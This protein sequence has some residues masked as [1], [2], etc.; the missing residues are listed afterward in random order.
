[1]ARAV[2]AAGTRMAEVLVLG[3]R[4]PA[5]LELVRRFAAQ[6]WR[7]H[8]ADSGP[9]QLGGWSRHVAS[10]TRLASPRQAPAD[11]LQGLQALLQR[12]SI[13]VVLPTCEEIFHL[14]RAR[15][16]LPATLRVLAM[17]LPTLRRLHSKWQVLAL[18]RDRG[19]PAPDTA[20]VD[21]LAQ[22]R[23][24]AAG[25]GVVLKP[26]YSRFGTQLRCHPGGIPD[27]AAE[28]PAGAGPWLAQQWCSGREV[29]SYA[30]ADAGQVRLHV[31][32]RP[33]YR[34]ATAASYYFDPCAEDSALARQLR[35][36][37]VQLAA[38]TGFSAQIGF[39]W[40]EDAHGQPWLL[41]CNPRATSGVHLFAAE[42]PVVQA[43][44]GGWPEPA[45][46]LAGSARLPAMLPPL[47]LARAAPQAL[48]QGQGRRWW[49]DLRRARDVLAIPGDR[50][51]LAG[52]LA[53]LVQ[54]AAAALGNGQGLRGQSTGDIEW[55]SED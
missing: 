21:T 20:R 30:I 16:A 34:L 14:A 1:M 43:L 42:E 35:A 27:D 8:V 18:A 4:A 36:H 53:D 52:A 49:R 19:V 41:E 29:C 40:I 39:D 54:M 32:Y 51:P 17:D 7:V 6:G 10:A 26:E 25:R 5:A 24:W 37:C 38:A 28:L 44:A 9:A 50:W 47:M 22:A 23:H 15:D 55:N 3:G 48:A 45:P 33:R 2:P 11:F 12:H 13:S 31:A 46:A